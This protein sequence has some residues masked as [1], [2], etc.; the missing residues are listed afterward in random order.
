M[1][2]HGWMDNAAYA[3]VG[4]IVMLAAVA[5][6]KLGWKSDVDV[7]DVEDDTRGEASK[8]GRHRYGK[9]GG[10]SRVLERGYT[11]AR[12]KA[13]DR[14]VR[15]ELA[16]LRSYDVIPVSLIRAVLPGGETVLE[17]WT[18]AARHGGY[19]DHGWRDRGI[20]EPATQDGSGAKNVRYA[21]A[22][23]DE[24]DGDRAS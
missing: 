22:G 7:G 6:T 9:R 19:C 1:N 2:D 5:G 24:R 17:I 4:G 20:E 8:R 10:V 23:D 12:H 21:R 11:C 14:S 15:F 16:A 18:D 13:E 3:A